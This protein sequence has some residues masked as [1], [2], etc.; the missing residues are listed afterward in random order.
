M[1][2]LQ[3]S[4]VSSSDCCTALIGLLA[5]ALT[6]AVPAL[7]AE[8]KPQPDKAPLRNHSSGSRAVSLEQPRQ[9]VLLPLSDAAR[10]ASASTDAS[11][12]YAEQGID[13]LWIP[14][15]RSRTIPG[16]TGS[17]SM[18]CPAGEALARRWP[19]RQSRSGLQPRTATW[20]VMAPPSCACSLLLLDPSLH[21]SSLQSEAHSRRCDPCHRARASTC[22]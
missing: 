13:E 20:S 14:R 3:C 12:Q 16:H 19:V 5:R 15:K 17:L 21:A 8:G 22:S 11:L 10:Q 2:A 7:Q 18:V 1:G 6:P 9:A 4:C